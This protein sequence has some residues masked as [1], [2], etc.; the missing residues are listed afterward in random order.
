MPIEGP[1]QGDDINSYDN[2]S[3]GCESEDQ[4]ND[5]DNSSLPNNSN[6]APAQEGHPMITNQN[7]GYSNQ[8]STL[9]T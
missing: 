7:M 5:Q 8:Q 3:E 4:N 6:T 2:E 1:G 9:P